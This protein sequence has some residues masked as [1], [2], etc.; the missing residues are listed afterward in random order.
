MLTFH[1]TFTSRGIRGLQRIE[2]SLLPQDTFKN[3]KKKVEFKIKVR[4]D[5]ISL[6]SNG[7]RARWLEAIKE[8]KVEI[9]HNSSSYV[10]LTMCQV[11]YI[12][13]LM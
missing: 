5:K 11:I 8:T 3:F 6:G 1:F 2:K 12:H 4:R 10:V 13:Y 7:R 9:L